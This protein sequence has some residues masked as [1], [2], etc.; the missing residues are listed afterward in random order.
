MPNFLVKQQLAEWNMAKES[1]D[2]QQP[3][4]FS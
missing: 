1:R 2:K 3:K 4:K